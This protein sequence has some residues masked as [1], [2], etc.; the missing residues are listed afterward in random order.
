MIYTVV[1]TPAADAKLAEIWNHAHDKQ[2]VADAAN[3]IDQALRHDPLTK[4]T[5]EHEGL[6]S[7]VIWP[8]AILCEVH[9]D[10]R[11]VLIVQ[12]R[13]LV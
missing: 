3:R 6:Y 5:H 1:G 12:V 8:L 2:A 4:V 9:P 11:L 7:Y 10:D 13:R